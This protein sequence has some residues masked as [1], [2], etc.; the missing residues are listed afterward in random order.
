MYK[1]LMT[2]GGTAGHVTPNIALIDRLKNEFEIEYVGSID[3]IEKSLISDLG[4]KFHKIS[5]GKLRRYFDLKNFTDIFRIV[6]G[7]GDANDII[8]KVKPDVIFSKGGFVT[9]PVVIAGKL[10]NVPVII[11]ESDISC[12]LANKLAMPFSKYICCSFPET[13]EHLP[14]KKSFL[15]ATPIRR[16]LFSGN[17]EKGRKMAGFENNMPIVLVMGGSLG[18][19]KINKYLR[20]SLGNLQ[21]KYNIIHLCGKNN[22]DKTINAKNYKQ[23]EYI[24]K[25]LEDLFAAADIVV[26]RSGANSISEFL[27]L[28]KPNLLIPLSK[29]ASRGD[30]I[31]NAESFLKQGFSKVLPEENLNSENLIKNIEELFS[32]KEKYIKRMSDSKLTNGVEEVC[33]IINSAI[34]K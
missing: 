33:K 29:K 24:S 1:I 26:S 30:Q 21:N 19:A 16:E 5:S 17:A 4:I 18:S 23:Y 14:K 27:A 32:E 10:N 8:K 9:V 7:L 34:K 31:L 15:T 6:K 12:G 28:K 20:E 22:L 11:H 13:L 2:G 25:N 3:G